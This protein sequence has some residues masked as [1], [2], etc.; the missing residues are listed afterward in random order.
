M[1]DSISNKSHQ[2]VEP[3]SRPFNVSVAIAL[4]FNRLHD[5][6]L[7]R[8]QGENAFQDVGFHLKAENQLAQQV[9][10]HNN[11]DRRK[12]AK[13]RHTLLSVAVVVPL[14]TKDHLAAQVC[15]NEFNVFNRR[16]ST[17][18][19][20]NFAK[21]KYNDLQ[22]KQSYCSRQ[23]KSRISTT[24]RWKTKAL[25]FTYGLAHSIREKRKKVAALTSTCLHQNKQ[26]ETK[27]ENTWIKYYAHPSLGCNAFI[28]AH[29]ELKDSRINNDNN[30]EE[31]T[32]SV[33]QDEVRKSIFQ[34]IYDSS[35]S[36][37]ARVVLFHEYDEGFKIWKRKKDVVADVIQIERNQTTRSLGLHH[38][39]RLLNGRFR[40]HY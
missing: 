7:T 9:A 18:F 22:N 37:R 4:P 34:S 6:L 20:F 14:I 23:D 35:Q 13:P 38:E 17:R 26:N 25:R 29:G 3:A 39:A 5:D 36:R 15:S 32:R 21:F 31:Y 8:R 24:S 27:G 19:N 30:G 12:F 28:A 10:Y 1:N 11:D 2:V 16:E 33:T 40:K